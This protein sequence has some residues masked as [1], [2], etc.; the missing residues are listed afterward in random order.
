MTDPTLPPAPP[1]A[2]PAKPGRGL[3]IALAVS[4]ALN[5]GVAGLVGGMILH[6][7]PRMHGDMVRDM[8]F[9]PFDEVLRPEDRDALRKG[10]QQRAGDLRAARREMQADAGAILA[11]LRADPFDPAGL[12]AALDGQRQHLAD[13]LSLG[14]GL[15][16]DF[17][18]ALPQEDRLDFA[19][20]LEARMKHG[21]DAPPK[22]GN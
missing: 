17:L 5:L 10:L 9:G 3:R 2:A 21:R 1:P 18:L 14:S 8:G 22:P 16:R 13:R 12:T 7:G 15:I 20:R 6:G 19:D 11:A 4:L